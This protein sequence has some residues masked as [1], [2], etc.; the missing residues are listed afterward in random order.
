MTHAECVD[1][2][3]KRRIVGAAMLSLVAWPI[4][5]AASP[6]SEVR[7]SPVALEASA[8]MRQAISAISSF[9]DTTG[10]DIEPSLDPNHTCLIGPEHT[11][12]FTTL[13]QLEAK[14][15]TTNPAMAG[16]LV[17]LLERAG[18]SAGDTIAVGAS[19]S[20]PAL[21]VATLT[22]AAAM[23]VHTITILSLGASSYGATRP[24]FSLLDIHQVLLTEGILSNA[25]AAVSL[26]G[27][28]DV[29]GEFD[30]V[31]KE[32]LERSAQARGL[33][34][35]RQPDLRRNV[36]E[37][38]EIYTGGTEAGPLRLRAFVNIGGGDANIGTSPLVLSVRPGLNTELALPNVEQRGVLYEMAAN[39]I[40]VVHLL[41]VR[42][43]TLRHSLPW[44][45]V[46]LPGAGVTRM[47]EQG[48][49]DRLGGWLIAAVYFAGL[50]LVGFTRVMDWLWAL[51]RRM[52]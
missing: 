33:R 10:I 3:L 15:T 17:Y 18:V 4:L 51:L 36:A 50:G 5:Q 16:L 13:G 1:D 8:R 43:L 31:L 41:N 29:G 21:L 7:L 47:Y 2:R 12:L 9:C 49:E 34:L 40:P 22:A 42:E 45:P 37:R 19:A 48:H 6:R 44:D 32:D 35:L 24:G 38:M 28:D 46:P 11:P 20:F 26:G 25:P 30:D 14:R 27:A 52:R 23:D 39:G